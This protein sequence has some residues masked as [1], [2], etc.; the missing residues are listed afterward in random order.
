MGGIKA[1]CVRCLGLFPLCTMYNVDNMVSR[2]VYNHVF[3]FSD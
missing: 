1:L 3:V 2:F